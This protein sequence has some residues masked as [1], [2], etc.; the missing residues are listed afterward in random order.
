MN[1]RRGS[2]LALLALAAF[3]G[4]AALLARSPPDL[5]PL[6]RPDAILCLNGD[7]DFSRVRL[8]SWEALRWPGVPLILSG[9]GVAGD[10]AWYLAGAA[11]ALGV[12]SRQILIEP[13]ASTTFENIVLSGPI[14]D[15]LGARSVLLITSPNHAPRAFLTARSAW[16]TR[17][18]WVAA[19]THSAR[20]GSWWV[21]RLKTLR[22][23]FLGRISPR[24]FV[25]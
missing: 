4:G 21:E 25:F 1:L 18:I 11:L 7:P 16:P 2:R 9:R 23:L 17:S 19:E 20:R 13:E 6:Q 3:A 24:A 10:S 5:P 14:L 22:Y 12:P 8:A 15:A